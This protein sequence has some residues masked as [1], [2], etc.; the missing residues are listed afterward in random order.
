M[1]GASSRTIR[2]LRL[3]LAPE[4]RSPGYA[5]L[6]SKLIAVKVYEAHDIA[7]ALWLPSMDLDRTLELIGAFC[8]NTN[9]CL[10]PHPLSPKLDSVYRRNKRVKAA[11]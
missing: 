7:A 4:A 1:W 5:T 11:L 3:A 8:Q 9:K 10:I 6:S 2:E